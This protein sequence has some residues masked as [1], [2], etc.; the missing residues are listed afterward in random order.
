MS[1]QHAHAAAHMRHAAGLVHISGRGLLMPTRASASASAP[2]ELRPHQHR[3]R[4]GVG[5]DA[6]RPR[7][8]VAA[9]KV[10][11]LGHTNVSEPPL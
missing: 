6:R 7:R 10:S 9:S 11:H 4:R 1:P 8:E 5:L 3:P 2:G